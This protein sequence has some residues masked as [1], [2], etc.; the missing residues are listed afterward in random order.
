MVR[1]FCTPID[2]E[3]H[4]T[5]WSGRVPKCKKETTLLSVRRCWYNPQHKG[6]APTK[7][8]MND[9]ISNVPQEMSYHT[10]QMKVWWPFL[11]AMT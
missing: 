8:L 10:V 2:A 11:T 6:K 5:T 1:N 9:P 7:I 3:M 4:P